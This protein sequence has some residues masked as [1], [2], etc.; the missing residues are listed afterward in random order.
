MSH[1]FRRKHSRL[2]TLRRGLEMPKNQL[3]SS[4]EYGLEPYT[5]PRGGLGVAEAKSLEAG[6]PNALSVD[7]NRGKPRPETAL[8]TSTGS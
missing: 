8:W 7:F 3:T 4:A 6:A 5:F 2:R 1:Y